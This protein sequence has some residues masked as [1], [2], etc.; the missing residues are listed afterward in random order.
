M[1]NR[2]TRLMNGRKPR[3]RRA[4]DESK[5]TPEQLK[6]LNATRQLARENAA[7]RAELKARGI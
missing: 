3:G 5:L 2:S 1:R 6:S 4:I 7:L